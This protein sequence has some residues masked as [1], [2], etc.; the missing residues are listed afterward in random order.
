MVESREQARKAI[1]AGDVTVNGA[2]ADKPARMVQAGDAIVIL[3]R[4]RFVGRG[5]DKMAG[6]LDVFGLDVT[7]AHCLDV[8]SS[9]GGFTDCLLQRGAAS[10]VA[11]DVGTHQLHERLRADDRV[12]VREQTDIREVSRDSMDPR[13]TLVVCDVSFIGIDRVL[14]KMFELAADDATHVLLIKPQFEA[15][16]QEVSRGRGV[17]RDAEVWSRVLH[18][19]WEVIEGLGAV[20]VNSCVSPLKGGSGNVE[21]FVLIQRSDDGEPDD[22]PDHEPD[23]DRASVIESLVAGA[24]DLR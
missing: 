2:P 3:E 18:E 23:G 22:E 10:V 15:G 1:A 5:G 19:A 14:P 21:F 9:T 7:G 13:P 20:V 12:D 24:Q 6:A 4:A 17:I 16:R 11:V 8:G